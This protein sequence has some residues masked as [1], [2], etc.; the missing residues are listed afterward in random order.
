MRPGC[1]SDCRIACGRPYR[2][3]ML[4]YHFTDPSHW[5]RIV[6][7]GVIRAQW[8]RDPDD[9][10]D[11]VR[12]VHLSASPDPTSLPGNLDTRPIRIT[13][14]VPDSEAHRWVPWA[15]GHLP[16]GAAST[17]T[18]TRFGGEPGNWYVVERPLP[19]SEWVEV[20]DLVARVPLWPPAAV[21]GVT[22]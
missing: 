11:L 9:L 4:L 22:A 8:P 1:N 5:E 13:A 15:W 7:S 3:A 6:A 17:L 12:T 2:A 14:D 21:E 10:P 18:S 20:V 16:P 19:A